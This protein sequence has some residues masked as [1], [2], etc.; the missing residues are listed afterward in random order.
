LGRRLLVG[1]GWL[2]IVASVVSAATAIPFPRVFAVILAYA[3]ICSGLGLAWLT[4]WA[5]RKDSRL[6]QFTIGSLLFLTV[7]VAIF[8]GGVRWIVALSPF[9]DKFGSILLPSLVAVVCSVSPVLGMTEAL[10]WLAV[11]CIKRR[12]PRRRASSPDHGAH[13]TP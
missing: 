5:E 1:L 12:P 2:A 4:L 9:R 10:L 6:G 3:L 13:D 7:F 11:W 8:F